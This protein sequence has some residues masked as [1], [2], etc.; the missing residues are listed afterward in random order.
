MVRAS[1]MPVIRTGT[2]ERVAEQNS[3]VEEI[4]IARTH[5]SKELYGKESRSVASCRVAKAQP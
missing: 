1:E 4:V 3:H 5:W 2:T